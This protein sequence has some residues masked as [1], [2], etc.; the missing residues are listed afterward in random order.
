LHKLYELY[1]KLYTAVKALPKKDRYT[2]GVRMEQTA[3]EILELALLARTKIGPSQLLI[4]N[5]IDI[6]LKMLK[7]FIRL[8]AELKSLA[9]GT[10]AELEG[11]VLEIGRMLGGWLKTA[12]GRDLRP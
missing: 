2:L 12:K 4:L 8:S 11:R 3:L 1:S 9:G 10:Y 7:L 6:K 5:K